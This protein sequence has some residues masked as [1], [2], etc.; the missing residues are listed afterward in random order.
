MRTMLRRTRHTLLG[1]AVLGAL[2]FGTSAAM[3]EV[4]VPECTDPT[5]DAP[6]AS[7]LGCQRNCDRLFGPGTAGYCNEAIYC[8]YCIFT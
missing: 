8:C 4:R 7:D 5:A 2:G 1:L 3:A 6:C